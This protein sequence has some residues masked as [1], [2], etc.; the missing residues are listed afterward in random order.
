VAWAALTALNVDISNVRGKI[1]AMIGRGSAKPEG[2]I[3]FTPRS[4]KVL[5]LALSEALELGHN[6]IGTEHVLLAITN[7]PDGVAWKVLADAGL[8]TRQVRDTVMTTLQSYV[9]GSKR[10]PPGPKPVV[11]ELTSADFSCSFCGKRRGDVQKLVAGPGVY[12]CNECV[13]LCDEIIADRER[14]SAD[15]RIADLERRIRDL[16]GR[17]RDDRA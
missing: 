8:G 3:P 7:E 6:Y 12:I 11:P 13:A 4:K 9:R 16:E 2:H 5:E 14:P 15:D 1:L 10:P 17:G